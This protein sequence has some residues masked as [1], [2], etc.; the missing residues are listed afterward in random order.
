MCGNYFS[1]KMFVQNHHHRTINQ[2]HVFY[3]YV[4]L[5]YG[6]NPINQDFCLAAAAAAGQPTIL[7]W[8]AFNGLL[9]L[10]ERF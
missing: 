9:H 6:H 7:P 3:I 10:C 2:T 8:N 5:W 1:L 4:W